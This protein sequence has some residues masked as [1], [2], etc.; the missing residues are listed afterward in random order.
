MHRKARDV[1]SALQTK[2]FKADASHH[3]YYFLYYQGKKSHIRTK[4]SH[5]ETDISKGL[6][7]AMARQMK[8]TGRQFED[9]VDCDLTG[10]AYIRLLIEAK[11]LSET[12]NAP[13]DQ[14]RK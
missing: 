9:F 6:C 12:A 14:K 10:D 3:W 7:S 4:I 1:E 11:E 2:G 5:N 8:L 13:A